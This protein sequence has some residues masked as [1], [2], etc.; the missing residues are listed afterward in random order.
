MRTIF[1]NPSTNRTWE[2]GDV[3]KRENLANTLEKI[4]KNGLREF[5]SGD[6]AKTLIDELRIQN[7]ILTLEDLQNYRA[8][9]GSDVET[10]LPN[11]KSVHTFPLPGSGVILTFILDIL[12]WY[13]IRPNDDLPLLYHRMVESFKWGYG[14]RSKL[15]DPFDE[16]YR[17]NIT[18]VFNYMTKPASSILAKAKINDTSTSN[19]PNFYGGDFVAPTDAGTSHTSVVAPNGDAVSVTST[20]NGYYGS[21]IMSPTTGII[22]NNE[23]DDFSS[24]D[25]TNEFGLPPSATNFIKPGKRPLSSMCPTIVL[26]RDIKSVKL[27]TGAAGGSKITTAVAQIIVHNLWLNDAITEAIDAK[28]IHHQLLPMRVDYEKGLKGDIVKGFRMRGHEI[29]QLNS[30]GSTVT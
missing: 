24:P 26:D 28:R 17:E 1:I 23:M 21:V 6:T 12:K 13:G 30:A 7:S 9:W 14:Y 20:V 18:Q 5:Y 2:E 10:N 22:M 16:E 15:G 19:D 4:G 3:Y 8:I 25:V 27:V 11:G 29:N